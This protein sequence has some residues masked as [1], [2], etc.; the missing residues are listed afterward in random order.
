MLRLHAWCFYAICLIAVGRF[1]VANRWNQVFHSAAF[2]T[3][4]LY[5]DDSGS[6]GNAAEKHIILAGLSVFE[7]MPHWLSRALD[8]VAKEVWPT[9]P[10]NLEFRGA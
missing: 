10:Q 5:L 7:R 4:L 6:V 3:H 1:A 9:D 2:F 8:N